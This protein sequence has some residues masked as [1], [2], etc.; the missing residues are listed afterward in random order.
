M[1]VNDALK[2]IMNS[3][4]MERNSNIKTFKVMKSTFKTGFSHY[5]VSNTFVVVL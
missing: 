2:F 3:K 5:L 1:F 4:N